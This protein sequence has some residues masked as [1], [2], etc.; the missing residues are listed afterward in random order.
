MEAT[1]RSILGII[2]LKATREALRANPARAKS[3][4]CFSMAHVSP[5]RELVLKILG[6]KLKKGTSQHNIRGEQ[7]KRRFTY[8]KS[9]MSILCDSK[10]TYPSNSMNLDDTQL[11]GEFS[12]D[13]LPHLDRVVEQSCKVYT[14]VDC[15]KIMVSGE[16]VDS[17]STNLAIM[18]VC[19]LLLW[20][21]APSMLQPLELGISSL[22]LYEKSLIFFCLGCS[23]LTEANSH[24]DQCFVVMG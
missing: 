10:V 16:K 2:R 12:L 19:M 8:A 13:E 22:F 11:I 5:C 4:L 7:S 9:A 17:L 20:Q 21:Q 6:D 1:S 14:N 18:K 15:F 3:L 24:M 23:G